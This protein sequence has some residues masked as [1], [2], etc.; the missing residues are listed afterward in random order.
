MK[1]YS[2]FK[3]NRTKLFF[4]IVAPVTLSIQSKLDHFPNSIPHDRIAD[5]EGL[6]GV[7]RA[8]KNIFE[9]SHSDFRIYTEI[10]D[11]INK[12][13]NGLVVRTKKFIIFEA[14]SITN[15]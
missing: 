4:G 1:V 7:S 12:I 11:G 9:F 8:P 2:S 6:S 3:F 15:A 13:R 10:N 14:V 5:D